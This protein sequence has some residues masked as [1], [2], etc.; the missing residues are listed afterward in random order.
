[1]R[2]FENRFNRI[3]PRLITRGDSDPRKMRYVTKHES[4]GTD[5]ATIAFISSLGRPPALGER[6]GLAF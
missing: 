4:P 3:L 6:A 5:S 2:K 1:M